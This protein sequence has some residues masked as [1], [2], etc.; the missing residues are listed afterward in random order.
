MKEL[1]RRKKTRKSLLL[2]FLSKNI[3]SLKKVINF[4]S[5]LTPERKEQSLKI[6]KKT[7]NL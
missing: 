7:I 6:D 5:A 3:I 2:I 1:K 4:V